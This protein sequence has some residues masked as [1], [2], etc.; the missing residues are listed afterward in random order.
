M[1]TEKTSCSSLW[2]TLIVT[3]LLS[4][5]SYYYAKYNDYM[6]WRDVP[7]TMIDRFERQSCHKS[8]CKDY[9]EGL[10]VTTDGK[11]FYRNISS[12][13]YFRATLPA[14]YTLEL[15]QFDIKQTSSDNIWWFF[16]PVIV[17]CVTMFSW[18]WLLVEIGSLIFP[19]EQD[20]AKHSR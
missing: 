20:N 3:L 19:E 11:R 1:T 12:Y 14:A 13:M 18:I 17:W 2:V 9:F 5:A 15:R 7:V 4:C 16:M 10:F 6:A 8:S